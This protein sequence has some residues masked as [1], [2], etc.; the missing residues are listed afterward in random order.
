MVCLTDRVENKTASSPG[1]DRVIITQDCEEAGVITHSG[2]QG[3]NFVECEAI[4]GDDDDD[5]DDDD[6]DDSGSDNSDGDS[7]EDDDSR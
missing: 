7:D 4:E 1:P 6:S 3:N 2:A 5:D